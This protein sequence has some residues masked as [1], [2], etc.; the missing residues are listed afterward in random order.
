MRFIKALLK[1]ETA[2]TVPF[3]LVAWFLCAIVVSVKSGYDMARMDSADK[4]ELLNLLF[5]KSE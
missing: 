2:L 4:A 1:C 5:G 3:F